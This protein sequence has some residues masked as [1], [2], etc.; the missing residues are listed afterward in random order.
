MNEFEA[1]MGLCI[2]DDIEAIHQ[3]RKIVYERY[4][5]EL[6]DIVQ[7]QMQNHNATQNYGYFP[8]VLKMKHNLGKWKQYLKNKISLLEDISILHWIL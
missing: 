8:V 5:H 4:R 2:L 6:K 1:A 3:K 7:M